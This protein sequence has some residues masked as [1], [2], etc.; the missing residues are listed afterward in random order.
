MYPLD[1]LM[2]SPEICHP[3]RVHLH[4]PCDLVGFPFAIDL[5][6]NAPSC[7][8]P[9]PE[10]GLVFLLWEQREREIYI[11]PWLQVRITGPRYHLTS[12]LRNYAQ[13]YDKTGRYLQYVFKYGLW[14]R[15]LVW[16]MIQ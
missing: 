3:L 15:C 10:V 11:F 16:Y 12:S 1:L 6:Y 4:F 5:R 14:V 2:I 9:T 8:C 13:G 7:V